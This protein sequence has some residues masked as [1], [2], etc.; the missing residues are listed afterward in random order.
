MNDTKPW[1]E[2]KAVWGSLLA[3]VSSLAGVTLPLDT[4]TDLLTNAGSLVGGAIALWGRVQA[5]DR[6][7]GK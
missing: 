1:Y 3:V 6:I 2:S 4:A 5:T 7:A